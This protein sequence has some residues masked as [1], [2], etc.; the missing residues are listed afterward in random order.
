[1]TARKTLTFVEIDVSICLLAYGVAPCTAAVGVTGSQKCFQ[2]IG[3]CQDRANY[4]ESFVTL[5]FTKDSG[6]QAESGIEA[7]P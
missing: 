5:R 4:A 1:V 2:T 3:S 6:Y 7:I